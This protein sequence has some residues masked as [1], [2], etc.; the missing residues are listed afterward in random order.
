MTKSAVADPYRMAVLRGTAHIFEGGVPVM[1]FFAR[2]TPARA[3][4]QIIQQLG[5]Q[6]V[7]PYRI[8]VGEECAPYFRLLVLTDSGSDMMMMGRL[9]DEGVEGRAFP[10]LPPSDRNVVAPWRN[11]I[12]R[13][14]EWGTTVAV[15]LLN[16]SDE[17]RDVELVLYGEFVAREGDGR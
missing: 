11:V 3:R 5:R 4:V 7:M 17:P 10:Y 15:S 12:A 16:A 1:T 2:A 8:C 9:P 14:L 13:R 6:A